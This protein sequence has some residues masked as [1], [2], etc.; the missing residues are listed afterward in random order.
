MTHDE[1][2]NYMKLACGLCRFAI[3]TSD[4]DLLVSMYEG[5][6]EKQGQFTLADAAGVETQVKER[7]I[8]RQ[9]EQTGTA[10]ETETA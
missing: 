9:A 2:I 6:V 5:I 10:P 1:K 3:S 4:M 8:K 7:E